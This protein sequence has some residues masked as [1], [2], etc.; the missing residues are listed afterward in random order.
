MALSKSKS[1]VLLEQIHQVENTLKNIHYCEIIVDK[2]KSININLMNVLDKSTKYEHPLDIDPLMVYK[3]INN[4]EL[5]IKNDFFK[6]HIHYI[7]SDMIV[8]YITRDYCKS[9]DE[10]Y[11]STEAKIYKIYI[12]RITA[13]KK[14]NTFK[15]IDLLNKELEGLL[16][17]YI[18]L[19]T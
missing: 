10:E 18:I 1:N 5:L 9:F 15:S 14:L 7:Y 11:I 8:N 2:Y 4:D 17:K 12:F 6:K 3:I 19:I 13:E 16:K